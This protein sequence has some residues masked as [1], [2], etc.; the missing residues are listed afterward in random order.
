[1]EP[2]QVI[3]RGCLGP[4][5]GRRNKSFNSDADRPE[6]DEKAALLPVPKNAMA[7]NFKPAS[8][9]IPPDR[10]RAPTDAD[11]ADAAAKILAMLNSYETLG[12][13]DDVRAA[14]KKGTDRLIF[15]NRALVFDAP[16]GPGIASWLADVWARVL[17]DLEE[18]LASAGTNALGDGMRAAVDRAREVAREVFGWVGEHPVLT[19][20]LLAVVTLGVFALLMPWGLGCLGFAEE[21]IV[22]GRSRL[23]SY[24]VLKT[25]A[26]TRWSAN[27]VP[28][29][30]QLCGGLA[31]S[32]CRICAEGEPI[33]LLAANGHD[34]A[35]GGLASW[36]GYL[37]QRIHERFME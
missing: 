6:V 30:R 22:A 15:H 29:S 28:L 20:A 13:T 9:N 5:C 35:S 24:G 4:C 2:L 11:A 25:R 1:M 7:Y 34:A 8:R 12:T 18:L 23:S 17:A 27:R 21:G 36:L 32:L 33:L 26:M 14:R 3:M 31:K 19:G 16:D 37:P 10:C